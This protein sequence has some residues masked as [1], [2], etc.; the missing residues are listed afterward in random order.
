MGHT[1][2]AGGNNAPDLFRPGMT[3][4]GSNRRRKHRL[5]P[6]LQN[7][8]SPHRRRNTRAICRPDGCEVASCQPGGRFASRGLWAHTNRPPHVE[9]HSRGGCH[10]GTPPPQAEFQITPPKDKQNERALVR[11]TR[12]LVRALW[13]VAIALNSMPNNDGCWTAPALS[14]QSARAIYRKI[15]N[16]I[17]K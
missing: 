9:Y 14:S 10:F 2:E 3:L 16:P 13:H 4:R 6:A 8:F 17:Y 5:N 1:K 12:S 15:R 7:L 11:G